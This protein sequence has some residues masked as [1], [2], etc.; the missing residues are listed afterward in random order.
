MRTLAE[1][2]YANNPSAYAA[3]IDANE[4]VTQDNYFYVASLY[5]LG[6]AQA[7]Q[8]QEEEQ[9]GHDYHWASRKNISG[10]IIVSTDSSNSAAAAATNA[11]KFRYSDYGASATAQ[12]AV[13]KT[14]GNN[15]RCVKK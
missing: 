9:Q 7:A 4:G 1:E 12:A 8:F 6:T 11:R 3:Y 15:V 5:R 10:E 2:E 14:S 13:A